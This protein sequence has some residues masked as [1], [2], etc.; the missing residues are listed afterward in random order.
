MDKTWIVVCDASK[1]RFFMT[2]SGTQEWTLFEEFDY[3]AGRA[4][5]IEL[6]SDRPGRQLQSQGHMYRPAMDP[7][8]DP[9]QVEHDRFALSIA[10]VLNDAHANEAF[11]KLV[12]V[13]PPQFLG[14]IR[15]HLADRVKKAVYGTL[16]KDYTSLSQAELRERVDTPL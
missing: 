9:R 16:D 2:R 11:D 1:A 5:G 14:R 6:M 7:H 13:A 3:P 4:K 15:G 10:N 12:I 8:T